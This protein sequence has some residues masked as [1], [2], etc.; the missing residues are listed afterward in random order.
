[1][2][3][4]Q[5]GGKMNGRRRKVEGEERGGKKPSRTRHGP[6]EWLVEARGSK[7]TEVEVGHG[8]KGEWER[9]ETI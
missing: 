1:M 6:R 2:W 7:G 4:A 5:R 3:G 8:S 9:T